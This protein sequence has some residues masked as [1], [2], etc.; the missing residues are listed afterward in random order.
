MPSGAS[1]FCAA[2]VVAL[3]EWPF[4]SVITDVIRS[5]A[6]AG[7]LGY[8]WWIEHKDKLSREATY[9]KEREASEAKIEK[10]TTEFIAKLETTCVEQKLVLHRANEVLAESNRCVA[11]NNHIIDFIRKNIKL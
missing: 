3:A 11:E 4:D 2:S 5:G 1:A 7:I 8:M 10:L 6:I 9:K